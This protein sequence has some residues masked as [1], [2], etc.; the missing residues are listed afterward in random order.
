MLEEVRVLILIRKRRREVTGM[1][2]LQGSLPRIDTDTDLLLIRS[3]LRRPMDLPD[4]LVEDVPGHRLF[5]YDVPSHHT[6][7]PSL[8]ADIPSLR[9]DVP[10]PRSG[11]LGHH[12]GHQDGVLQ[13]LLLY[14]TL[15]GKRCPVGIDGVLVLTAGVPGKPPGV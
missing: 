3:L 4:H 11:A 14:T 1:T 6:G 12:L 15:H 2:A 10:G 9:R 13:E 7:V 5:M 8:L